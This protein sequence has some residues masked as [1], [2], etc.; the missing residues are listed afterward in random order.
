MIDGTTVGLKEE[1][2]CLEILNEEENEICMCVFVGSVCA[3]KLYNVYI[4]LY[5]Y[6]MYIYTYKRGHFSSFGC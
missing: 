2:F 4:Y 5:T 1:S 6:A 3:Y